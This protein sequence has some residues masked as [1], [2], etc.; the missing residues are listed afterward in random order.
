MTIND[1]ARAMLIVAQLRKLADEI[2]A[3]EGVSVDDFDT[4]ISMSGYNI[5]QSLSLR[6]YYTATNENIA[7]VYGQDMPTTLEERV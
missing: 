6:V 5:T 2:E 4:S 7:K 3:N 1:N